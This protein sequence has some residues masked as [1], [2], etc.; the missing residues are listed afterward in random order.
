MIACAFA[1]LVAGGQVQAA[2]HPA[3]GRELRELPAGYGTPDYGLP[4]AWSSGELTFGGPYP[5]AAELSAA[6]RFMLAGAEATGVS[7]DDGLPAW[8]NAVGVKIL[9]AMG[10]KAPRMGPLKNWTQHRTPPQFARQSL[11]ELV[12]QNGVDN[13]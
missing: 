8:I 1:I 2:V 6:E 7:S 4:A 3:N 11:H 12:K 9:T 13:E 10:L 5:R